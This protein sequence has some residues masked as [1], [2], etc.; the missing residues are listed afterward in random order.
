MISDAF[1]LHV[2]H[3]RTTMTGK[4]QIPILHVCDSKK[5]ESKEIIVDENLSQIYSTEES[6]SESAIVDESST[7]ESE[8]ES[9]HKSINTNKENM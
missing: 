3:V 7:E 8:P 6:R 1:N 4:Q 2:Y 9:V 5:S